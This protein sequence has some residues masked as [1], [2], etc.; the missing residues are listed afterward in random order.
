MKHAPWTPDGFDDW[1]RH[2]PAT[3]FARQAGSL[4]WTGQFLDC[5]RQRHARLPR[6]TTI[7]LIAGLYSEFLSGCHRDAH[8]ALT[9]AGYRV[10]TVPVRSARGVVAQG[11]HIAAW[12]SQTLAPH[13]AFVALT[14]SKGGLDTIAA[15]VGAPALMACCD[16]VVLVQP[17]VGPSTFIDEVF[18]APGHATHTS[19]RKRVAR[20]MLASRWMADGTRDISSG[21][22]PRIAT[23]LQNIPESVHLIHAVSWSIEASTR[24]DSHHA[25]LNA[26]R[27]DCA[28][29]G[30]FYLEQQILPGKPQVC[31][32]RL[33]HGQP[34]L[35]GLNF[36]AGRFW[37]ALA[38]LLHVTRSGHSPHQIQTR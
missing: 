31:L 32:P 11:K 27:P 29:D 1:Q 20:A 10:L 34:V 38:D 4:D 3:R 17:P 15:L 16:G 24:F 18:S 6:S 13:E 25:K 22:D 5:W 33:D 19:L 8:R 30:Q 14:H 12:L 7:V 35:G 26:N 28:H 23:L 21:R 36:D 9:A 2:Y 37:L